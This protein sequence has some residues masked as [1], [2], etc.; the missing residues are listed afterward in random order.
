MITPVLQHAESTPF[1][2]T[3]AVSGKRDEQVALTAFASMALGFLT[4][5]VLVKALW[6]WTISN[7]LPGAVQ[8]GLIEESTPWGTAAK[9]ALVMAVLHS[10]AGWSSQESVLRSL[11]TRTCHRTLVLLPL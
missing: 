9:L 5:L 10:L 8:Q 2:T 4:V 3:R 7:L 6:A 1:D 11:R